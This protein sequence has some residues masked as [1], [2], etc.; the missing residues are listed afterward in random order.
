M[1]I[2]LKIFALIAALFVFA[3]SASVSFAQDDDEA[4]GY[5]NASSSDKNVRDAAAFAVK[6]RA[7]K[8]TSIIELISI[9]SARMQVVAGVNFELCMQ[10]SVREKNAEAAAEKYVK[11]VV[12][13]DL[14][15]AYSLTS[16][17]EEDCGGQ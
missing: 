10:I 13:R 3:G 15:N 14:K 5:V 7:K 17:T 11:A 4:G 6:E 16:W 1:K 9:E 8:Q 2:N 12:Y